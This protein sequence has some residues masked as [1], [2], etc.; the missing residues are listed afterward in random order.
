MSVLAAISRWFGNRR[1]GRAAPATFDPATEVGRRAIAFGLRTYPS[2]NSPIS[3]IEQQEKRLLQLYQT[4]CAVSV[5]ATSISRRVVRLR[6]AIVEVLG[7]PRGALARSL[8]HWPEG[9]EVD[10]QALLELRDT[11]RSLADEGEELFNVWGQITGLRHELSKL[12]S[13]YRH[14]LPNE[15][16]RVVQEPCLPEAIARAWSAKSVGALTEDVRVVAEFLEHRHGVLRKELEALT[17]DAPGAA[18]REPP[19][20]CSTTTATAMVG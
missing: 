16:R 18:S 19:P 5:D 8:Q 13:R 14:D 17:T 20:P 10:R 11:L 15:W 3:Q 6:T 7:D 1:T 9:S 12:E 4:L 2:S